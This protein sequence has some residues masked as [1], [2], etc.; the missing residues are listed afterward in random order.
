MII[1]TLSYDY[2]S[3]D[4]LYDI[5]TQNVLVEIKNIKYVWYYNFL[6]GEKKKFKT[7]NRII[8][9]FSIRVNLFIHTFLFFSLLNLFKIYKLY[10]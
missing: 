7:S 1:Q 9:I 10:I 4:V 2:T 5:Q 8:F 6:S 3:P